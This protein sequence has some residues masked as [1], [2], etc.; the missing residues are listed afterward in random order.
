MVPRPL[1]KLG[2]DFTGDCEFHS[3]V[4]C[5]LTLIKAYSILVC[6]HITWFFCPLPWLVM[7]GQTEGF[8]QA[9]VFRCSSHQLA[10]VAI[11]YNGL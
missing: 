1:Q 10:I 2:G 9:Q 6:I 4:S 11:A 8:I 3:Y 7:S 5:F